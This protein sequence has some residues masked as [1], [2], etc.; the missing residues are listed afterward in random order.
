[1]TP[2]G[3]A[4]AAGED[5]QSSG[6]GELRADASEADLRRVYEEDFVTTWDACQNR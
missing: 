2:I 1:M 6:S 5:R 4:V 3:F